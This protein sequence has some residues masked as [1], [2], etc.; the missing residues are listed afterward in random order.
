MPELGKYSKATTVCAL[1]AD[2]EDINGC[3]FLNPVTP[4]VISDAGSDSGS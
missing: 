4:E 2:L 1:L 3:T